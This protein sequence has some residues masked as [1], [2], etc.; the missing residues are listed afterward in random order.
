MSF[1]SGLVALKHYGVHQNHLEGLLKHRSRGPS[2][3]VADSVGGAEESAFLTSS[4]PRGC[5]WTTL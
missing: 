4:R 3:R 5:Y 1:G 2:P